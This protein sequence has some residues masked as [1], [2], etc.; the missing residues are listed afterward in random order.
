M[1]ASLHVS[2]SDW[3]SGLHTC[4]YFKASPIWR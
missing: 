2:S 1:A 3:S 4:P